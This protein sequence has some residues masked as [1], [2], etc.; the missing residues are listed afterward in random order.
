MPKPGDQFD[1]FTLVR[2]T[3]RGAMG[4]VWEA[5][6]DSLD[7]VVALKLLSG[8]FAADPLWVARFKAE[9]GQA[10]RLSH[11]G[12]LPVFAVGETEGVNWFAMELV[13]GEDLGERLARTG[14][15]PIE[16]A[17]RWVRDAALALDH[18]HEHGIVHRDVKPANLMLRE[19]GRLA[20]TD[21]GLAKTLGSGALT[22]TGLLV[23]TPYYMSPEIAAGRMDEIG[24]WTDVYG[25]GVTLYELLTGRPPFL[26]QSTVA[27]IRQITEEDPKPPSAFRPEIPR[28]LETIVLT[29]MAKEPPRRYRTAKALADDLDRFLAGETIAVRRPG[30]AERMLRRAKRHRFGVGVTI[31]AVLL[32]AA[33][34]T[35]LLQRMWRQEEEH[36][37]QI[38][39]ILRRGTAKTSEDAHDEADE[40]LASAEALPLEE[41]QRRRLREA[42]ERNSLGRFLLGPRARATTPDHVRSWKGQPSGKIDLAVDPADARLV[43]AGLLGPDVE[44]RPGEL[45]VPPGIYRLRARAPDRVDTVATLVVPP[46]ARGR[47]EVRMPALDP[48]ADPGWVHHAGLWIPQSWSDRAASRTAL[49]RAATLPPYFLATRPATRGERARSLA[50]RPGRDRPGV[51][52]KD[53]DQPAT[54]VPRAEAEAYA[55]SAG[56]RLP[57]DLEMGLAALPGLLA[58]AD[59]G[60]PVERWLEVAEE[61]RRA[62]GVAGLGHPPVWVRTPTGDAQPFPNGPFGRPGVRRVGEESFQSF[63]ER[64]GVRLARDGPAPGP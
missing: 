48:T 38:E 59:V 64:A 50:A 21:F 44:A 30:F 29:A 22:T 55:A 46:E 24:P 8:A 31:A 35:F 34:A 23:G 11:P 7:R 36:R 57:T 3:G 13:R 62:E 53:D 45:E 40:I 42:L 61:V 14:P 58:T 25:L 12:I 56:A 20:I 33:L 60:R 54:G 4:T 27:L 28:D 26:S 52:S 32:V 15:P 63:Q 51:P 10:S 19:D 5:R 1:G 17:T 39:D 37:R 16:E 6:Q 2:E 43:L 9:A 47:V 49:V 18:A 41:P